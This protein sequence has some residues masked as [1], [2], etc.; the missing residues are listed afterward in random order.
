MTKEEESKIMLKWEDNTSNT[1]NSLNFFFVEYHLLGNI[2]KKEGK[3]K[4]Q[5]M[6]INV[7]TDTAS[8]KISDEKKTPI[9]EINYLR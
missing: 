4:L 7:K 8:L 9:T 2:I 5:E 1:N 6:S 3:K